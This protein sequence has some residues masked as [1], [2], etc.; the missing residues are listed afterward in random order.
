[1]MECPKYVE[2]LNKILRKIVYQVGFLY[3]IVREFSYILFPTYL[4]NG[5]NYINF[6][7]IS[8][9]FYGFFFYALF[10]VFFIA[11]SI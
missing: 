7:E 3:K 10:E 9:V 4:E 8:I 5:K 2:K 11:V 6:S 1:M